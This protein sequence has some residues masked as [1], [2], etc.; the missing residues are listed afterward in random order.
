VGEE[1]GRIRNTKKTKFGEWEAKK[2]GWEQGPNHNVKVQKRNRIYELFG[3]GGKVDNL[4]C[5][6]VYLMTKIP[7]YVSYVLY[8]E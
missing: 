3:L 5:S 2:W 4:L 6:L 7:I 1:K 8:F